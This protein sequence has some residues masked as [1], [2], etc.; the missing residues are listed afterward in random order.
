M[1]IRG[2]GMLVV[3]SHS[4]FAEERAQR[5]GIG[6]EIAGVRLF[7]GENGDSSIHSSG[8]WRLSYCIT[9]HLA[10]GYEGNYG[11]VSPRKAGSFF[12]ADPDPEF[13]YKTFLFTN[14]VDFSYYL[15]LDRKLIENVISNAVR[16]LAMLIMRTLQI[17]PFGR[18]D[19]KEGFRSDTI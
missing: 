3:G 10:I 2:F 17:S 1:M 14:V 6:A 5:V 9:D 8:G 13:T 7:G 4:P 18:N 16:N 19:K 11:W 12:S 15:V